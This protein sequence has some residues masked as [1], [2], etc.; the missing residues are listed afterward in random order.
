MHAAKLIVPFLSAR[1]ACCGVL[2][3]GVITAS[4]G[5]DFG[6]SCVPKTFV[7]QTELLHRKKR[8]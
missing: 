4:N 1:G 5:L 2:Q 6:A 7:L 3:G 8:A